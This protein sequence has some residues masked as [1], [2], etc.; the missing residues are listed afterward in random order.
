[1]KQGFKFFVSAFLL[2]ICL[3]STSLIASSSESTAS[4]EKSTGATQPLPLAIHIMRLLHLTSSEVGS[5]SSCSEYDAIMDFYPSICDDANSFG[6]C[7]PSQTCST[8]CTTLTTY[9]TDCSGSSCPNCPS[10][11]SSFCKEHCKVVNE[12]PSKCQPFCGC[13]KAKCCK[14]VQSTKAGG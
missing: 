13:A 10:N 11:Y 6:D 2:C 12:Y 3:S 7:S 9:C 4:A 8:I 14:S 5:G 1:M